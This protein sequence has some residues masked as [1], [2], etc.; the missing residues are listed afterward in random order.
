MPFRFLALALLLPLAA[1]AQD[2]VS[3]YTG[4]R[5]TDG[6]VPEIRLDEQW[7]RVVAIEGVAADSLVR[8]AVELDGRDGHRAWGAKPYKLLNALGWTPGERVRLRIARGGAVRDTVVEPTEGALYR[9]WRHFYVDQWA[10]GARVGATPV[11]AAAAA[12]SALTVRWDGDA[13]P[14]DVRWLENPVDLRRD[15]L[16]H[17]RVQRRAPDGEWLRAEHAS[18]DLAALEAFLDARFSYYAPRRDAFRASVD[19]VRAGLGQGLSRA[20]FARQVW[21]LV[22]QLA[23]GHTRVSRSRNGVELPGAVLPFYPRD[24]DGRVVAVAYAHDRFYD[25][26]TPVVTHIAGEPVA[27]WL[28][29][30]RALEPGSAPQRARRDALRMLFR[31][32]A[33]ARFRRVSLGDSV[34]VRL[35]SA[36]GT[37][38]VRRRIALVSLTDVPRDVARLDLDDVEWRRIGDVGYLAVRDMDRDEDFLAELRDAMDAFRDTRGLVIDVR[39][40]GGGSR[41]ALQTLLPY[42]LDAPRVVNAA[43]LRR[44]P[45]T[46]VETDGGALEARA[47]LPVGSPRWSPAERR[48]VDAWHA[49][50]EPEVEL[51]DSLFGRWHAM[52]VSPDAAP[53]RYRAPVVILMDSDTFSATDIFL[54]AFQG[55]PGVTLLGT[56]SGGGSGYSRDVWL[57]HSGLTVQASSMAS[58][59]PTGALYETAGVAPDILRPMTVADWRAW[60]AGRDPVLEAAVARLQNG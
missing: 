43:R 34:T 11:S 13:P 54:G 48:A 29:A 7:H 57:P 5:W 31:V 55:V 47:M 23:D 41:D 51:P 50:F 8:L 49:R 30:A 56:P 19:T 20:D 42:V 60:L 39:G 25:P 33:L 22:N 1:C 6:P 12:R 4:A 17:R 46:T 44:D 15:P 45:A 24:A 16:G 27:V 36:D 53:F 28:R 38:S 18:A 9:A 37:A 10:E 14:G 59:L 26:A 3:P 2:R 32:E 21:G 35:A 52:V 58:F 40:N